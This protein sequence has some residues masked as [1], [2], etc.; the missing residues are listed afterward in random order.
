MIK[1]ANDKLVE[2]M[3]QLLDEKESALEHAITQVSLNQEQKSFL[4]A[5]LELGYAAAFCARTYDICGSFWTADKYRE[6]YLKIREKLD[7]AA[8]TKP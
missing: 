4:M 7:K 5:A 1:L 2:G 6:R 8:Q 3:Q